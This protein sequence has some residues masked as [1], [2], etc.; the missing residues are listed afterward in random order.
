MVTVIIAFQNSSPERA[1]NLNA[2]LSNLEWYDIPCIVVE[3]IKEGLNTEEKDCNFSNVEY[4]YNESNAPF[5]KS[6]L[7]NIGAKKSDA[8]YLWFLDADVML[9]FN[10]IA[11]KIIDQDVIRPFNYVEILNKNSTDLFLEGKLNKSVGGKDSNFG[12]FSI[13]IKKSIYEK[14][15]GFDERFEGWGWED[16]DFVH[17]KINNS[18]EVEVM[19]YRGVHLWHPPADRNRE[20]QNFY[21]YKESHSRLKDLSFCIPIKNRLNQLKETLPKNLN[22]NLEDYENIEFVLVDFAS[23]DKVSDWVINNF[24]DELNVQYLKLFKVESF[25]YWESS[26]AKNT[27]HSLGESKILTNLDCDNFTGFRGGDHVLK[28]FDSE[29]TIAVHQFCKKEWFSGNYGR[30]SIRRNVFEEIGGYDESFYNMGYQDTDLLKR[31]SLKYPEGII[32]DSNPIYNQA[33]KNDKDLSIANVPPEIKEKG[34]F[35][36]ND[37]N[38]IKSES[39]IKN[40]KWLANEGVFGIRKDVKYFDITKSKFWQVSP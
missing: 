35:W 19:P 20:R 6:K 37:E 27:A 23:D 24:L 38:K 4:V 3:Q 34:F 36:M 5:Q 29:T 13:I 39:N 26:L 40:S 10:D 1:R 15:G 25:P 17:N 11:G 8:K 12:K 21:I 9:K 33:I 32:E 14:I 16:I 31:I 18:Y 22:D 30:I 2:I 28:M 7:L